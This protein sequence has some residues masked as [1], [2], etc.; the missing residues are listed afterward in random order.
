MT[1]YQSGAAFR[2]ALEERLRNRSIKTGIPLVRLRKTVA[3]DRFLARLIR[4]Q[5]DSWVLKGGFAIQLRLVD[6]ARTTKDIDDGREM[7]MRGDMQGSKMAGGNKGGSN[8]DEWRK[9]RP[10]M[11]NMKIE[12]I[13]DRGQDNRERPDADNTKHTTQKAKKH[14]TRHQRENRK[15]RDKPARG[16]RADHTR[17]SD[18]SRN[19]HTHREPTHEWSKPIIG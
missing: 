3:F 8:A 5:P 7:R 17:T 4:H 19:T 11:G 9:I 18:A 12:G 14:A 6:K 15:G 1:Q 16:K 13:G 10:P 2:R